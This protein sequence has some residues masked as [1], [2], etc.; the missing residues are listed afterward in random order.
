H[1][2]CAVGR[3]DPRHAR[4]RHGHVRQRP[5]PHLRGPAPD[6]RH[7]AAASERD[8]GADRPPPG[9]AMASRTATLG[10]FWTPGDK[11]PIE[12]ARARRSFTLTLAVAVVC[13]ALL[14]FLPEYVD[15]PP[16]VFRMLTLT[17]LAAVSVIGMNLVF[18]LAG[19]ATL[20]PAATYA[21]GAYVS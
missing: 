12:V 20:G 10:R 14:W 21:V 1:H 5:V 19:Q 17:C 18:G 13:L 11:T 3:H 15:L 9:V 16:S 7:P 4:S 2:G 8:R 6:A